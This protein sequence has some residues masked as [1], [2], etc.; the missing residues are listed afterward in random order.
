[1]K[2]SDYVVEFLAEQGIQH[3]FGVTGGAVVHLFDSANRSENIQPVF[4]HH[5]QAA[6]LAA[7]AYA[8]T[9]NGLG[10]AFVTTGPGGTNAIT[11]LAA[12]WLDSLPAIFISGQTRVAHTSRGKPIRQLGTQENDIITLVTPFTKYAIMLDDPSSIQYH[13]QKAVHT[14]KIG[15]PGPV[16]LDIPQDLQWSE[17]DPEQL[18]SFDAPRMEKRAAI[19]QFK[20]TGIDE[21]IELMRASSRPMLLAGA[22]IKLGHA[23]KEFEQLVKALDWP[24]VSTWNSTDIVP[25]ENDLYVGRPG[26]FGQRGANLA[27]QNSDL[28]IAL[29]SHLCIDITGTMFDAFAREAKRIMVDIDPV[30][31]AHQNVHIDLPIESDVKV[32]LQELL[33]RLNELEPAD[34]A[35]WREKCKQ[36][37]GFNVVPSA[38][39]EITNGVDPYVFMDSL[40]EELNARD[41]IVVDGGGTVNQLTFQAIKLKKGQQIIISGGLCTMGSG[42]P[43]AVGSCFASGK[44]RTIC[45]SGDGSMQFNIQELQTIVHHDLPV[46]IFVLDNGGYLSIR[47]TQ[48]TFLDGV[49]AGSDREGGV[50]TPD[51][52]KVAKAYGI[53]TVRIKDHGELEMGIRRAL[54]TAGPTLCIVSV[55]NDYQMNPRQ[56]FD[57]NADGTGTP[58][59]LEDMYPLLD[60]GIFKAAMLID[61]YVQGQS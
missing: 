23:E 9:R 5:E 22:G 49:H 30:E 18:R 44:K 46:K 2:L 59:P 53:K 56:G 15:R 19:G 12:A 6:A 48:D 45:L 14:A 42:L 8:R 17:I 10:A 24:F 54:E 20:S 35:A 26:I 32:F 58:R 38:W 61:P 4:T 39:R 36:Y 34:S 25:C 7:E 47:H 11:G 41:V 51:F 13:L 55:P 16:W 43:E 28:L 37:A 57:L 40:S 1:M 52:E 27:V 60:R 50:S 33:G 31:L 3:V 21:C 29:G